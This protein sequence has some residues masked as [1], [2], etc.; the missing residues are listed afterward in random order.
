[1]SMYAH[2]HTR[3]VTHTHMNAPSIRRAK[4]HTTTSSRWHVLPT[5]HAARSWW[6]KWMRPS[7][8]RHNGNTA[9]AERDSKHAN[10]WQIW[11][12]NNGRLTRES[13][14]AATAALHGVFV[15]IYTELQSTRCGQSQ[16]GKGRARPST[17]RWMIE[18][19]RDSKGKKRN[20]PLW[21]Y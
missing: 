16:R 7:P 21:R 12:P 6:P 3:N 15:Q 13:A 11:R 19:T 18:W 10:G 5:H 9:S 17:R 14:A 4:T 20:V 2:T 1:M 8:L